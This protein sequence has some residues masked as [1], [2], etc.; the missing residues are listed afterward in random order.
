MAFECQ[1]IEDLMALDARGLF[2]Q[3]TT[4]IGFP[5]EMVLRSFMVDFIHFLAPHYSTRII[6]E[7]ADLATQEQVDELLKDIVLPERGGCEQGV[8]G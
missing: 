7:V 4:W 3:V 2:P 8:A 5:R 1:D 6:R